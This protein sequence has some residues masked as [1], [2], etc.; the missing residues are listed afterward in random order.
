MKHT[1]VA[2]H[3]GVYQCGYVLGNTLDA[4]DIALRDGAEIVELDAVKS[5][6]GVLFTYHS[7]TEPTR[8]RLP[9]HALE[10]MPAE[11][12]KKL[13]QRMP[14]GHETFYPVYTLE[15]TFEHLRGRCLINVDRSWE[16]LPEVVALARKM[17]MEEQIILKSGVRGE[18]WL[19]D[20]KAV[21]E[22]A[23]DIP[24]MPVYYEEDIA[25][26]II[27]KMNLNVLGAE[28]CFQKEDSILCSEEYIE[29]M[30]KK[31]RK[32]WVN[33]IVFH[34]K[35]VLT[36]GHND[37]VSVLDPKKGW[38]WLAEKGYDIIQTDWAKHCREFL[39]EKEKA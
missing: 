32:L 38:G 22:L 14:D 36:A 19:K 25:S 6:D 20:V 30:H 4:F 5:Q 12:I 33:A 3:Q 21:E 39:D 9:S 2:A 26:E 31:N 13:Y 15:D 24:Y 17:K 28:I 16:C 29:M 7:G 37:L 18:D 34:Y 27:D 10:A 35:T 8:L 11:E 1:M 23:P